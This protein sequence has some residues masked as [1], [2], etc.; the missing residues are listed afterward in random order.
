MKLLIFCDKHQ[1]QRLHSTHNSNDSKYQDTV[2]EW[3]PYFVPNYFIVL[4]NEKV[5]KYLNNK[6]MVF[7]VPFRVES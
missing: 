5:Y 4:K 3:L 2:C 1:H 7:N 6:E